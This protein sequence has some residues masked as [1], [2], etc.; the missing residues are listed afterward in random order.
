LLINYITYTS[1]QGGKYRVSK[2][3]REVPPIHFGWVF[4]SESVRKQ[5][6][7]IVRR[8]ANMQ[9]PLT[10]EQVAKIVGVSKRTIIR[11]EEEGKLNKI[12]RDRNGVRIYNDND[13]ETIMA[14]L[15]VG[16]YL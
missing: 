16:L 8:F 15:L 13:I 6:R 9:K 4:P 14:I 10:I 11:W 7:I 12:A 5:E 2:R 1:I 3:E